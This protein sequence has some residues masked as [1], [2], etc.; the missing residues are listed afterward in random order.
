MQTRRVL[1]ANVLVLAM[2]GVFFVSCNDDEDGQSTEARLEGTWF[3]TQA[4][5]TNQVINPA[6]M[7]WTFHLTLEAAHTFN[8][9]QSTWWAPLEQTTGSWNVA[10]ADLTLW[11]TDETNVYPYVLSGDT[12]K[13]QIENF[14]GEPNTGE[15]ELTRQH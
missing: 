5:V 10:G 9:E 12:L 15:L 11:T 6:D 13:L 7:G 3:L 14:G 4:V 1:V 2:L 8:I